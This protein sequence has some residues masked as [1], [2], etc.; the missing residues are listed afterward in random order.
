M[1]DEL[2]VRR[3][4]PGEEARVAQIWDD[5][6]RAIATLGIDQWQ[7][8]WPD[9]ATADRSVAEGVCLVAERANGVLVGTL[10][11]CP[12][13]DAD[14][15]AAALPW[16]VPGPYVAL[17]RVAVAAEARRQGV[18]G[19]MFEAALDQARAAGCV[20]ARIDTHPGNATM[21]AFVASQGFFEVGTLRLAS[22]ATTEPAADPTRV[23][24]ERAL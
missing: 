21:R 7:H 16:R 22:M 3:A 9:R 6:R 13:P 20:A 15:E 24:F 19:R 4:R 2:V 11:L 18:M 10:C 23:A 8:G 5:G 1:G 12:G 17:H 14:Y